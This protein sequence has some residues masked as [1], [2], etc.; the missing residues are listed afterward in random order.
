MHTWMLFIQQIF[1]SPSQGP[2]HHKSRRG[3]GQLAGDGTL[4]GSEGNTGSYI[5]SRNPAR[6]AWDRVGSLLMAAGRKLGTPATGHERSQ[7][8]FLCASFRPLWLES[9]L[10]HVHSAT[11][12]SWYNYHHHLHHLHHLHHHLHHLHHLHHPHLHHHYHHHYHHLRHQSPT[13]P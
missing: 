9:E 5:T 4:M 11:M 13:T 2:G 6:T 10:K 3:L 8:S 12:S 1:R 7:T